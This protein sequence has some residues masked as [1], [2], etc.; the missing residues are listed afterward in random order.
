MA[1][2]SVRQRWLAWAIGSVVGIA[3]NAA[4]VIAFGLDDAT[5]TI[6]GLLQI[7]VAVPVSYLAAV[8]L[9]QRNR[10]RG[11]ETTNADQPNPRGSGW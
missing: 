11:P 4:L 6:A 5:T 1:P 3:A 7:V 2:L 10:A 8:L 9:G